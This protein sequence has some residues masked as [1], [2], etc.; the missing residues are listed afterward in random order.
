MNFRTPLD[1]IVTI[2]ESLKKKITKQGRLVLLAL[3]ILRIYKS[4]DYDFFQKGM[5][6]NFSTVNLKSLHMHAL[7]HFNKQLIWDKQSLCIYTDW[8]RICWKLTLYNGRGRSNSGLFTWGSMR[9]EGLGSLGWEYSCLQ[10]LFLEQQ[11]IN[12]KKEKN[13]I[14]VTAFSHGVYRKLFFQIFVKRF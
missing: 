4:A 5:N 11:N 2:S 8:I 6:E 9:G 7:N 1:Q 3:S 14:H 13:N 12:L 10:S